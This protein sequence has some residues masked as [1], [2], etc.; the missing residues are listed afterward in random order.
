[1]NLVRELVVIFRVGTIQRVEK[2]Q[3]VSFDEDKYEV[4]EET[5][6]GERKRRTSSSRYPFQ[7]SSLGRSE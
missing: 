6:E 3:G 5:G 4:E 1:M 7:R 2:M